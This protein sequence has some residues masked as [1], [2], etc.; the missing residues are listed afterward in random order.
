MGET[1][2]RWAE[3]LITGPYCF[4]TCEN[5]IPER[6]KACDHLHFLLSASSAEWN[7]VAILSL[8]IFL[9][10]LAVTAITAGSA[11]LP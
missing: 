9:N 5:H 8:L 7:L 3:M 10:V 6:Q 4:V 11:L 2:G 1:V